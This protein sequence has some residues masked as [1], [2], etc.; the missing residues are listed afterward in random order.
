MHVAIARLR[1]FLILCV[2]RDVDRAS[3]LL[4]MAPSTVR[5]H[6]AHLERQLGHQLLA[7]RSGELVT[8]DKGVRV[9]RRAQRLLAESARALRLRHRRTA[10]EATRQPAPE[11]P[12]PPAP[13]PRLRLALASPMGARLL[14][15]VEL[16][17]LALPDHAV[18]V[19]L[20][21]EGRQAGLILAGH[22]DAALLWLPV[23]DAQRLSTRVVARARR[24][25]LVHQD[26][27]LARVRVLATHD[28][29]D[30]AVPTL[31]R[32]SGTSWGRFWLLEPHP[33][34][35]RVVRRGPVIN[36]LRDALQHVASKTAVLPV[37]ELFVRE[38]PTMP[39]GES[40]RGVP[41]SDLPPASAAVVSGP[42]CQPH[43]ALALFRASAAVLGA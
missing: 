3:Y 11:A 32:A 6:L 30:R 14:R 7:G 20:C 40:L 16:T 22:A 26:D 23:E 12:P 4:D 25:V 39:G 37:P 9:H 13:Y 36:S 2:T 35:P 21:G 24:V 33:G 1:T 38:G 28:L 15:I 8:T 18:D 5:S 17:R 41:V 10:A 19:Q 43:V 42:G 27:P 31:P 29:A 34:Q